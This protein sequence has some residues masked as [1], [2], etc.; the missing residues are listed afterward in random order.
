MGLETKMPEQMYEKAGFKLL[1]INK[2]S[3]QQADFFFDAINPHHLDV[4]FQVLNKADMAPKLAKENVVAN[5]P[6]AKLLG[7]MLGNVAA[8]ASSKAPDRVFAKKVATKL[9]NLLPDMLAEIGV[10]LHVVETLVGKSSDGHTTL[11]SEVTDVD[12]QTFRNA[13]KLMPNIGNDEHFLRLGR[14][15]R[16][17]V[18]MEIREYI[19]NELAKTVEERSGGLKLDVDVGDVDF[20]KTN[21]ATMEDIDVMSDD[22]SQD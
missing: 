1:L 19:K 12:L 18:Y 8:K 22:E 21:E 9:S 16:Q 4:D 2:P 6:R 15:G 13:T 5:H 3:S 14:T 17:T 7:K 10:T 11:R 20:K